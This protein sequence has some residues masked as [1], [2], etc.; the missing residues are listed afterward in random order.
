MDTSKDARILVAEKCVWDLQNLI[1]N[2]KNIKKLG[3]IK[4]LSAKVMELKYSFGEI[5]DIFPI[6]E[7]IKQM[8]EKL[9]TDIGGKNWV[10]TLKN[11]KFDK[12]KIAKIRFCLNILYNL[13]SRMRLPP[14]PAYAVDIRVGKIESTMKHPN[15][16]RLKICNVNVG[17]VIT[18]ITNLEHIREGMKLPVALLPPTKLRGAVSEGMFLSDKEK[19]VK[20]GELPELSKEELN[21][22]R[23]EILAYLRSK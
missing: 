12:E 1:G 14:D 6:V 15:A 18:V 23:K 3:I 2:L 7:S 16:E 10:K 4:D 19:T 21:N 5:E 17:K 11:M 20:I 8:T 9:F 22:V 13:D